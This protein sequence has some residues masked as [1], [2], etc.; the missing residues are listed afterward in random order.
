MEA[1]PQRAPDA[2]RGRGFK[3]R[4]QAIVVK[5]IFREQI[6]GGDSFRPRY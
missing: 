6:D 2:R 1:L 5:I 4:R 3:R